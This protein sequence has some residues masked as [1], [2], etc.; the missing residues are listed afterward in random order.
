MGKKIDEYQFCDCCKE[1]FGKDHVLIEL[2]IPCRRYLR[3]GSRFV[4]DIIAV[5]LCETCFGV[6]WDLSDKQF[7]RVTEFLDE[8]KILPHF[9]GDPEEKEET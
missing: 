1:T 6:Y 3:D 9:G 7:A 4:K 5:G 2:K 8:R